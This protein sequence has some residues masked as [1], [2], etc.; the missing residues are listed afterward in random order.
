MR[1][2]RFERLT[3]SFGGCCSIQLSYGRAQI[4]RSIRGIMMHVRKPLLSVALF[5][6][7]MAALG[8]MGTSSAFAQASSTPCPTAPA[9]DHGRS[10][11]GKALASPAATAETK[12]NGKAVTIHYNA[13]SARCRKVMGGVVPFGQ[14]WRTGANPATTLITATN[15]RIGDLEVPA[16]TY[17]LY[18]M[19]EAPGTPW[20][21]IVNKQTGQW[22]TV[23]KQEM[24]LGRTSMMAK[25][26]AAPQETMSI[27]FEDAHGRT[28]QLHIRWADA[29]EYVKVEAN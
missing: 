24:D 8:C 7:T 12:L 9:S 28:A 23:Y 18:T 4:E 14:V 5:S 2:R 27:N 26:V 20:K 10:V 1:P 29:D 13:P 15:L 11:D 19:P 22:G 16:G 21:L 3:Y 6:S 25:P 17:T